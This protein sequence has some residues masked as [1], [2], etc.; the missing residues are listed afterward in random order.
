MVLAAQ[1]VR[2]LARFGLK[3]TFLPRLKVGRNVAAFSL[4]KQHIL[5]LDLESKLNSYYAR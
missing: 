4:E 1:N 2:V 5:L 3:T